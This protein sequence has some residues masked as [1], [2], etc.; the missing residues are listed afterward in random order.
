MTRS[1]KPACLTIIHIICKYSNTLFYI[2]R[3]IIKAMSKVD[4]LEKNEFHINSRKL[5]CDPTTP[6]MVSLLLKSGIAK[7]EK[8]AAA[9]LLGI[10][11]ITLTCTASL[12]Y[13]RI[14]PPTNTTITDQYGN[15]YTFEQ[16]VELVRQGKD[17]LLQK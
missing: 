6:T 8:Q 12:I 3:G 14:A 2:K 16:Y 5:F 15:V 7:N 17:P 4:F 10:I 9:I 13:F 11:A 1:S